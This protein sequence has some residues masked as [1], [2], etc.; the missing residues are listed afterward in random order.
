[1]F[2]IKEDLGALVSIEMGK[3]FPEGVGEVVEFVD[4][5]DFGVGLVRPIISGL[6]T[7]LSRAF[8]NRIGICLRRLVNCL[9]QCYRPNDLSISSWKYVGS[10][11]PPLFCLVAF[12]S[13]ADENLII[14]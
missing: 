2:G 7:A 13:P 11:P 14:C 3:I 9:E 5:C 1:M 10:I 8:A 4:I 6:S 12:R